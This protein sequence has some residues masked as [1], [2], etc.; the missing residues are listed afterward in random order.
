M[1]PTV[2]EDKPEQVWVIG[3]GVSKAIAGMP[4][5]RSDRVI[6]QPQ[7]RDRAQHLD[8]LRRL[9]TACSA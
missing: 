3:K 9:C 6:S 5:I 8:G 7:D 2:V 1:W 4:G